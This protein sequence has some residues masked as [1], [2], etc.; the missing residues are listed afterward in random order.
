[1]CAS[2]CSLPLVFLFKK[3]V[4]E[5]QGCAK[6]GRHMK[7]CAAAHRIKQH[8]L[9]LFDARGTAGRRHKSARGG[10]AARHVRGNARGLSL[11]LHRLMG[12]KTSEQQVQQL[13]QDAGC[14]ML[15]REGAHF[16]D[17]STG[18]KNAGDPTQPRLGL[19]R[20]GLSKTS[21]GSAAAHQSCQCPGRDQNRGGW[22]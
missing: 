5:R 13:R 2:A 18:C 9:I 17:K 8:N 21:E 6:S 20:R 16:F 4:S 15:A 22:R 10:E 11:V 12:K 7:S 3:D 1:M 19:K 14:K